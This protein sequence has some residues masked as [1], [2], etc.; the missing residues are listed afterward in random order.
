[1]PTVKQTLPQLV[2]K[3]DMDGNEVAGV[4]SPLQMAP[5][6]TYTGWNV[7]SSGPFKGQMCVFT[8]P[9]GGFIPFATTKAERV[10]SGDPRLSLEERYRTHEGYV[11]ALSAA[12]HSLVKERYL[13]EADAESMIAQADASGV[14]RQ[15]G[16][17]NI[18]DH[19]HLAAPDQEQAA[20][21]YLKHIGGEATAEGVERLMFGSTRIIFQKNATPKSSEG[22]A[23]DLIGFSV[24][25]LDATVR[26]LQADGVKIEMPITTIDGIKVAQVV[27]PS[28]TLLELVQDPRKLGLNYICLLA[29]NPSATLAWYADKIGGRVEKFQGHIEGI[30]YGGVWILARQGDSSP[31]AGHAIDHIGFRPANVDAAVAALK[32]KNVTVITEPRPLTLPSGTTM[33]LAFIQ[34]PDGVRVELVQRDNLK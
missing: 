2:P 13:G 6:G 31:S 8:S 10:A 9:A 32:T 14:L 5:L 7:L 12:A 19:I 11:Q 16:F 20:Q 27:D 21:W 34:A 17:A 30:N 1:V 4:K 28:G 25:N 3:V 15:A 29:P 33:R 23:L 22:S 26:Q 18:V 24:A